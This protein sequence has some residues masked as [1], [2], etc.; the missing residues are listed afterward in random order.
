MKKE[1]WNNA[2]SFI[3]L[4]PL[5]GLI[6]FFGCTQKSTTKAVQGTDRATKPIVVVSILPQAYF[7]NQIGA[8]TVETVVLVGPGKDPHTYEP[9]PK[10]MQDLSRAS[11]WILSNTDFELS[12]KPKVASIYP[13]LLM[14]DGTEGVQ[15]RKMETH[16]HEGEET[17]DAHS[18]TAEPAAMEL[19]RHTWLGRNNAKILAAHVRDTLKKLLPQGA[20]Q[21]DANY[22]RLVAEIDHVFDQLAQDLAVLRG[23][24]VFVF[25]P[26]FGYFFDEFGIQQEA[27]ETGGKEPNAQTLAAIMEEA[28]K[29]RIKVIFVQAQFPTTAAKTI[30][31]SLGAQVVPLD[32][33]AADWMG[34]IVLMGEALRK[35]AQ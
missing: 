20:A 4:I 24:K 6:V 7:V 27:I 14:V 31:E 10:Q 1:R 32:P 16:H 3:N 23:T 15:F 12:L 22:T 8:D 33:L 21:Y 17:E 11:A 5:V 34:N 30:A 29:D 28:R 19:D 2:H 13:S 35:A 18:D 26:S 25:H 9:T